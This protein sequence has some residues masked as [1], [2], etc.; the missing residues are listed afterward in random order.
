[1]KIGIP[2][3]DLERRLDVMSVLS[4]CGEEPMEEKAEERGTYTMG[5]DTGSELHVVILKA[6]YGGEDGCDP[7]GRQHVVYLGA[8][9]EFAELDGL[10]KRFRVLRCVIDGLPETHATRAFAVRHRGKVY[11]NF[12]NEHQRGETKWDRDALTV[13]VN[14]TEAL[15]AS[16]AAVREKK[17]VLPRRLP[18]VETFAR[19]MA[20]DAKILEEDEETG[21]KR[22][23]YVRTGEDHFSLA[24]TYAWMAAQLPPGPRV[25]RIDLPVRPLRL[26][27]AWPFGSLRAGRP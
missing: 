25:L 9:H 15:D 21:A 27:G 2:W 8:H 6:E 23:K 10:M 14:R 16:R 18:I 4:L 12:F 17:V 19:H 22:Y 5:I 1:M 20:A 3:A 13:Q 24:F 26:Q 7:T 11:L